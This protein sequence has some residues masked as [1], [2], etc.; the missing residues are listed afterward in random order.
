MAPEHSPLPSFRP[1]ASLSFACPTIICNSLSTSHVFSALSSGTRFSL[2]AQFTHR[3]VYTFYP[4]PLALPALPRRTLLFIACCLPCCEACANN[5]TLQSSSPSSFAP[6]R[7][8]SI[9][10]RLAA[11]TATPFVSEI[12]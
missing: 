3:Q 1:Q 2:I 5:K 12:L 9:T 4:E 7:F 6:S 8:K 10:S 11:E